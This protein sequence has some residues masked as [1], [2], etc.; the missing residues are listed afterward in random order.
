MCMS[1]IMEVKKWTVKLRITVAIFGYQS[2]H[3]QQWLIVDLKLGNTS[4]RSV[5]RQND[6]LIYLTNKGKFGFTGNDVGPTS[7]HKLD[8]S[9]PTSTIFARCL[10]DILRINVGP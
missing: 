4:P 9:R 8:R 6:M 7:H 2:G 3:Q 10:L 1:I 5:D